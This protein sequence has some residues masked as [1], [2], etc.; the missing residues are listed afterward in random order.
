MSSWNAVYQGLRNQVITTLTGLVSPESISIG[1]FG[2]PIVQ[3]TGQPSAV[4]ELAGQVAQ[5]PMV[6]LYDRGMSRWKGI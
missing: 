4:M 3:S 5:S 6:M 2:T 1:Y